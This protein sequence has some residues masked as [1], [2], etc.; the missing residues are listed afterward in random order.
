MASSSAV[1]DGVYAPAADFI[2]SDWR[3]DGR[4]G[5]PLWDRRRLEVTIEGTVRLRFR[6]PLMSAADPDSSSRR[7]PEDRSLESRNRL[8]S[9]GLWLIVLTV[10]LVAAAAFVASALI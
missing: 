9:L 5:Q 8:P 4:S 1:V 3:D 6:L 7:T 2:G 10:L